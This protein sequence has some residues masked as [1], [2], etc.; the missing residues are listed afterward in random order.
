MNKLD[1]T[2]RIEMK[3]AALNCRYGNVLPSE[4]LTKWYLNYEYLW[5]MTIQAVASLVRYQSCEFSVNSTLLFIN[6]R[7][8]INK[9]RNFHSRFLCIE[10]GFHLEVIRSQQ[11][12]N[13]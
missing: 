5:L 11:Y 2:F 4:K 7:Q 6:D 10:R 9:R 8:T 12:V 1:K 3:P 13:K